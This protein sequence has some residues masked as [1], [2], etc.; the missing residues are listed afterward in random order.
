MQ[1]IIVSVITIAV[2]FFAIVSCGT[3]SMSPEAEQFINDYEAF[4]DDYCK[5]SE[6]AGSASLMD[7]IT[8]AQQM[9][10][11]AQELQKYTDRQAHIKAGLTPDGEKR[12][13]AIAEKAAKC[14][15]N[16]QM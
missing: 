7:K 13:E 15:S 2:S 5:L 4:V 10:A 14:S 8:L 11:K 9:A 6:K 12:I 3:Q 1:K 16:F